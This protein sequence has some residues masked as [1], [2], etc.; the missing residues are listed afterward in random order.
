MVNDKI[1]GDVL[2]DFSVLMKAHRGAY[3]TEK[4]WEKHQNRT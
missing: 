1:Y 4:G 3:V 2:R